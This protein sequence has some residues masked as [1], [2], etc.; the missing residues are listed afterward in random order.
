M[1]LKDF[2]NISVNKKTK[3]D[4]L[5]LKKRKLKK[6]GISKS[7]LLDLEIKFLRMKR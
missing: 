1:K 5:T 3:Q 6:S 7:D 4:V 2:F